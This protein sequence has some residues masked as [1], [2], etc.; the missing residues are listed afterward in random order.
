[1]SFSLV[2]RLTPEE[3]QILEQEEI[4]GASIDGK[5]K[6][7]VGRLNQENGDG[8]APSS[9]SSGSIASIRVLHKTVGSLE[10]FELPESLEC[11][12]L[13]EY[14]G[15]TRT[16]AAEIFAR[17]IIRPDQ[18]S[19]PYSLQEK[20]LTFIL[21]TY[22]LVELCN[23]ERAPLRD[24][25]DRPTEAMRRIGIS[26]EMV[27]C[28][29]AP[30]HKAIF[31]TETLTVWLNI[32][33]RSRYGTVIRYLDILKAQAIRTIHTK[34]GNMRENI[35]GIFQPGNSTSDTDGTSA[36]ISV[37]MSLESKFA[38][39][40]FP[41]ECVTIVQTPPQN[42]P[43]FVTLYKGMGTGYGYQK[44]MTLIKENGN[45]DM[46]L[47]ATYTGGDFNGQDL[48]WYWTREKETAEQY[49]EWAAK[50]S[51]LRDCGMDMTGSSIFGT[52]K[53][54]TRNSDLP[55]NLR[56]YA[57]ADV[58]EGHICKRH[59]SIVPKILEQ[60]IQHKLMEDDCLVF[61]NGTKSTQTVFMNW[62]V[63]DRLEP[64]IRANMYIEVHLAS[65][66]RK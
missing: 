33:T 65:V 14:L 5:R 44:P 55:D 19:N 30:E 35:D 58:M 25:L 32:A 6:V 2:E 15:Y 46:Q 57:T 26:E 36:T 38:G 63:V 7:S 59:P 49:R 23:L 48:A 37:T 31:E 11:V 60:D 17:W 13:V 1:M 54:M 18:H 42:R 39:Q 43:G 29:M 16:K 27:D 4:I 9:L 10:S 12:A 64:L 24:L 28:M 40:M 8:S 47:I 34:K 50:A 56:K 51:R 21:S 3:F 66:K 41:R 53:K 52:A 22:A 61:C 45:L 20:L 62:E